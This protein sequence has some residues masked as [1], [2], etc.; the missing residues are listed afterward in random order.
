MPA[1]RTIRLLLAVAL[2]GT[3]AKADVYTSLAVQVIELLRRSAAAQSDPFAGLD[4]PSPA[5]TTTDPEP[6]P[7]RG[8]FEGLFTE[9]LGFRT[10]IM[11]QFDT[12]QDGQPASRQSIGFEVLKKFS[13]D[14]ETFASFDFQARL[15]RRDGYNPVPDDME[16]AYQRSWAFEYDNLYLDLYNVFNPILKDKQRARN[17][18]RFNFRV[19][20][21]YVPFGL[22]LQTDTHGTLLQL[23]NDRDF[24]FAQDWYAGFWGSINRYWNY[25]A[26]YMAG[27]GYD[28]KFKGQSGLGALR[29]SLSNQ[30]SSRYGV[31]A[32][33][34]ILG[35]ERLAVEPLNQQMTQRIATQRVGLD[36]RYRHAV[37]TGLMTFTSEVSGGRDLPD[38]VFMQL[39]QADYLHSSRRWGLA[40]QYRQFWQATI[41]TDASVIAEATWYFRNDVGNSN[42]HWIKISVEHHTERQVGPAVIPPP[43]TV[44]TLQYYFY[45]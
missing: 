42:L 7:A 25:D 39:Y 6:A 32:G 8:F 17:V 20:H 4:T 11:S 18:G 35:G 29:L 36:G 41:G 13:T 38:R 33:V 19:G 40:T 15:V 22:N 27:S 2:F 23:S 21:F 37:P 43:R 30:F 12:N 24:G 44:V 5:T 34:S 26:Y 31:E 14:T 9:N 3:A 16:G 10:E 1:R 28:L 45:R